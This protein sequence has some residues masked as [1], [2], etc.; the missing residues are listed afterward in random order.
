MKVKNPVPNG[1]ISLMKIMPEIFKRQSVKDMSENLLNLKP[2]EEITKDKIESILGSWN[3]GDKGIN[4]DDSHRILEEV[5][6]IVRTEMF[7]QV[8]Q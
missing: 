7:K 3:K 8:N 2:G 4:P 1:V 6:N 5:V